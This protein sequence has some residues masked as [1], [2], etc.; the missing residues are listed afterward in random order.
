MLSSS[1]WGPRYTDRQS[2]ADCQTVSS[3]P[4]AGLYSENRVGNQS[5]ENVGLQLER[6]DS[7]FS[8]PSFVSC[9]S[10]SG[11]FSSS[12][13]MKPRAS[14]KNS[15]RPKPIEPPCLEYPGSKYINNSFAAPSIAPCSSPSSPS[16]VPP[17]PVVPTRLIRIFNL[18]RKPDELFVIF[19]FCK[20]YG[21]VATINDSEIE[22]A[23]YAYI[24]YFDFRDAVKAYMG[25]CNMQLPKFSSL[26]AEYVHES[27]FIRLF[28]YGFSSI[29]SHTSKVIICVQQGHLTNSDIYHLAQMHGAVRNVNTTSKLGDVTVHI[30]EFYD[31]RAASKFSMQGINIPG[32]Q[33]EISL[34]SPIQPIG[35]LMTNRTELSTCSQSHSTSSSNSSGNTMERMSTTSTTPIDAI[36]DNW[37]LNDTW[38]SSLIEGMN[39]ENLKHAFLDNSFPSSLTGNFKNNGVR[40]IERLGI[41][42][43]ANV[44]KNNTVDL[45]KIAKGLD[46]RTTLMLRNIPNKVDQ[47][48]LKEYIDLTNKNTYDFLCA[49][50]FFFMGALSYF[51]L[52]E[53]LI[54]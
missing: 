35:S 31:V 1:I 32:I 28:N 23:G 3:G 4:K 48:M 50:T 21:E 39:S 41:V 53:N 52:Q 15:E 6:K 24:L 27:D 37:G 18:P 11:L 20:A 29:A 2:D 26:R 14:D 38:R 22:I 36:V 19:E 10:P 16:S 7:G 12:P 33:A 13:W 49:Y 5:S 45:R 47:N 8:C 17:S 51:L 54:S 44:P 42:T 34:L 40:D 25:L 9:S 43:R 30:C 46:T